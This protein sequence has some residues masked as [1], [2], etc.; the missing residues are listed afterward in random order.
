MMVVENWALKSSGLISVEVYLSTLNQYML[1]LSCSLFYFI[2]QP[3]N[4]I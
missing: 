1:F 2:K 3:Y 4:S